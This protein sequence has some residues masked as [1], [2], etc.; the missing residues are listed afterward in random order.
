MSDR[1]FKLQWQSDNLRNKSG[2]NGE[3]KEIPIAVK[4]PECFSHIYD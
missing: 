3:K 4:L 1:T 2:K